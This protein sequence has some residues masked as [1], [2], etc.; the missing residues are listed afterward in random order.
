[1]EADE[2]GRPPLPPPP[3]PMPPPPAIATIGWGRVVPPP[4]KVAR[5][6][7]ASEQ[8]E[9]AKALFAA[10]R[11][12]L[13]ADMAPGTPAK[14]PPLKRTRV[15]GTDAEVQAAGAV[16]KLPGSEGMVKQQAAFPNASHGGAGRP[17]VASD[18]A[19]APSKPPAKARPIKAMEQLQQKRAAVNPQ[20]VHAGQQPQGHGPEP[21][22]T[23]RAESESEAPAAAACPEQPGNPPAPP[24]HVQQMRAAV[25]PEVVHAGQQLQ[26]HGGLLQASVGQ[27][28][29][30]PPRVPQQMPQ[31][32]AQQRMPPPTGHQQMAHAG[33]QQ[34]MSLPTGYQQMQHAGGQHTMS[35]PGGHQQMMHASRQEVH[36][37]AA[38][39]Q[40]SVVPKMP[41]SSGKEA[42]ETLRMQ[43]PGMPQP[44]MPQP[45]MQQPGMQQVPMQHPGMQQPPMQHPGMQQVPMQHPGMQQAPMQQPPMQQAPMQHRGMQQ[46]PMQQ[47]PMQQPPMPQSPM[48]QPTMQ[49]P[50]MQLPTMQQP[51]MQVPTM[52]VPTMPQP[53]M[54]P[55][56]LPMPTMQLPMQNPTMLPPHPGVVQP[57]QPG[58]LVPPTMLPG[59][60][61]PPALPQPTRMG[62]AIEAGFFSLKNM[63]GDAAPGSGLPPSILD[64]YMHL[65][66]ECA[67]LN[68]NASTSSTGSPSPLTKQAPEQVEQSVSRDPASSV[69]NVDEA[70][71]QAD[72]PT[73]S[74]SEDMSAEAAPEKGDVEQKTSHQPKMNS[75]T[76][77]DAWGALYRYCNGRSA[78]NKDEAVRSEILEKWKQGALVC[79][80]LRQP[81]A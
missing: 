24:Q 8:L 45:G 25:N 54:Q 32:G 67:K 22:V 44:G 18:E 74:P 63:L 56:V 79:V 70:E 80:S 17:A 9:E 40:Q 3:F 14:S 62:L 28:P 52:Q 10:R 49:Q 1:M 12:A 43:Q 23:G 5:R 68:A 78:K 81:S 16:P 60:Q 53:M 76:H 38:V 4:M 71:K 73:T 42:Q 26:G 19:K 20:V 35:P 33:V 30:T 41:G 13:A 36:G 11:Q 66:E 27:V 58:S 59:M 15:D 72:I 57:T 61:V 47:P 6:D 55:P 21:V 51:T 7:V 65:V 31:A 48:Q 64:Q 50:T 77:P 75:Q 69:V 39:P 46:P 29:K 37:P 2:Y 34:P